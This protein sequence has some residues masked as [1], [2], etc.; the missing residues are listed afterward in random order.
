MVGGTCGGSGVV[1]EESS[2]A[3][4]V[5]S[6]SVEDVEGSTAGKEGLEM[7]GATGRLMGVSR[8]VGMEFSQPRTVVWFLEWE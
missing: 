4:D 6:C 1:G 7:T 3:E 8:S 2:S 5:E